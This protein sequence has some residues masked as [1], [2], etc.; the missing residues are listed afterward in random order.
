MLDRSSVLQSFR[1][2]FDADECE[3]RCCAQPWALNQ[4]TTGTEISTLFFFLLLIFA[5]LRGF[6]TLTCVLKYSLF[7]YNSVLKYCLKKKVKKKKAPPQKNPLKQN[8]GLAFS[9]CSRPLERPSKAV[10]S[11][12]HH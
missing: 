12:H 8:K 9:T 6:V 11:K 2:G 7:K 3:T 4:N 10:K 5:I 1:Y